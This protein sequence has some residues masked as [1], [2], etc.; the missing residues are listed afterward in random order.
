MLFWR[1]GRGPAA[2]DGLV[3][4]VGIGAE[5]VRVEGFELDT[6]SL[7]R[8][9]AVGSV[10]DGDRD[11]PAA[12][13]WILRT[14]T[15]ELVWTQDAQT[16]QLDNTRMVSEDS[17]ML[18]AGAYEAYF[19]S[20]GSTERSRSGRGPLGIRA[21]WSNDSKYWQFVVSAQADAGRAIPFKADS[22]DADALW[23]T[24]AVGNRT[25]RS[26]RLRVARGSE[27]RLYSVAELCPRGCDKAAI[28]RIGGTAPIWEMTPE[29]TREAGGFE[30]NRMFDGYLM[31][32]EGLYEATFSTNRTHAAESWTANPPFDPSA[33]GL[34]IWGDPEAIAEFDPWMGPEPAVSFTEVGN[35]QDLEAVIE[36]LEPVS[37]VVV[38]T[39]EVGTGESVYDYGWLESASLERLWEM[40]V[41]ASKAAGGDKTNRVETAFLDLEPGTYRVRYVSDGSHA[42]GD[43]RRNEPQVPSRWGISVFP[44]HA[45]DSDKITVLSKGARPERSAGTRS[46]SSSSSDAVGSVPVAPVAPVAPVDGELLWEA[47]RVGNDEQ[48]EGSLTFDKKTRLRIISVGEISES[49]RYDF[50]RIES[51]EGDVVWEMNRENTRPAGGNEINRIFDGVLDLDPG[52]YTVRF[53]T[54]FSH[55]FGDFGGGGPE[56]PDNWGV[57]VYRVEH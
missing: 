39:G 29:N 36:V 8:I 35:D 1:M 54:D 5:A 33:W 41:R 2:P 13:G 27:V 38:S 23:S 12:Y 25:T 9:N 52:S 45:A 40:T 6:P 26:V 14:D 51:S 15:R 42:F 19:A 47:L 17:L 18:A 28:V 37:V 11:R 48:H 43:W 10:E 24:G 53:Q 46:S 55:A 56:P 30:R 4:L 16:A 49:D 44:L 34:R 3:S 21:H 31:L 7:V 57:R 50:T 22:W 20:F 32:E